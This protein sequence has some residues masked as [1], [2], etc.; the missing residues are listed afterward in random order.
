M[1]MSYWSSDVCS[2]DLFIDSIRCSHLLDQARSCNDC[3]AHIG[4]LARDET[5]VAHEPDPDP[6]IDLLVDRVADAIRQAHIQHDVGITF[7]NP[8]Q[9][10]QHSP[11]PQAMRCG[12][13]N[14]AGHGR[15]EEHTSELQ[16][17]MRISYAVFCLKNK[18]DK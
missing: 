11:G 6:D 12:D 15:S 16:S 9:C 10:R 18:T 5:T 4:S 2:S 17:L 14:R 8:L 1:R 3:K 13:T 7:G